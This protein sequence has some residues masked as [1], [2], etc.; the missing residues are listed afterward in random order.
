MAKELPYFKFEPSKWDNG[1]IQLCS[2]EAQGLFINLCCIYWSRIGDLPLKLAEQKL[3]KSN[4]DAYAELMQE[5]IFAVNDGKIVIN[6]LDE[7]LSNFGGLSETKSK[8]AKVRWDKV[9]ENQEVNAGAMQMQS[10]SNAIRED[11]II[12]DKIKEDDILL[13]KETKFNVSEFLIFNGAEKD[14]VKEWLSVRKLK[15]LVNTKTAIDDFL[16]EV[17]KSNMTINE[18]LKKCIIKSWGGFKYSWVLKE[19]KE[20]GIN[21]NSNGQNGDNPQWKGSAANGVSRPAGKQSFHVT[22]SDILAAMQR[23]QED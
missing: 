5:D 1:N 16:N 20:N 7:Q 17:E 12:Q 18:V 22:E 23:R 9:R 13:E 2:F 11:K 3:F 14:L 4:A 10:K 8:A 6:F 15:K 21:N 19:I